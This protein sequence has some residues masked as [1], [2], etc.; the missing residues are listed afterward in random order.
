M[1]SNNNLKEQVKEKAAEL[2]FQYGPKDV[3]MDEI[4]ERSGISKK[5]IYQFFHSKTD[6]VEAVVDSLI[7]SHD[8]LFE[9]VSSSADNAIEEVLKQDAGLTSVCNSL[10]PRF[11]YQLEISFPDIWKNLEQYKLKVHRGIEE[12]LRRGKEEGLY[13]DDLNTA[14]ISDIRLQ[15]LA[16]LLRPHILTNLSLT[17]RELIDQITLLYLRSIST[18]KGRQQIQAYI[19]RQQQ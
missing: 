7:R 13:R 10:R 3:S 5:T 6:I 18:E 11:F 14:V 1:K 15:Q 9:I 8:Q 16:N 2:F 17:T 4:A 19:E 12:N